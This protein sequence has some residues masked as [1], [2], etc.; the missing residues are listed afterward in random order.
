MEPWDVTFC[1]FSTSHESEFDLQGRLQ[2]SKSLF[3]KLFVL[4]YRQS[5]RQKK[6]IQTAIRK[7]KEANAVLAR[8]NS[9]L[10]QQLK[11]RVDPHLDPFPLLW[12]CVFI[13]SSP[14]LSLRLTFVLRALLVGREWVYLSF[15]GWLLN[16]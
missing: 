11:V 15:K 14:F 16:A 7:N 6:A 1:Q 8:L 13:I 3:I 12:L 9:E 5:S 10:Q 4:S 2:T